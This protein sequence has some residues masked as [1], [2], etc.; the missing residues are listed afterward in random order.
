M[1]LD[2]LEKQ[3][4]VERVFSKDDRRA[5]VVQLT[6][7]GQHLFNEVFSDH[8]RFVT[9]QMSVLSEHEQME[10]GSLL[11]KLGLGISEGF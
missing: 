3:E 11:K 1:V 4:L 5:I 8:A 2:N 6:E 10:L 9:E 7:K